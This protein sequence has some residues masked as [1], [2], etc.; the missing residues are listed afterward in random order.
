MFPHR[1]LIST[2]PKSGTHLIRKAIELIGYQHNQLEP[3]DVMGKILFSLF[4]LPRGFV[5]EPIRR[6]HLRRLW[7]KAAFWDEKIYVDVTTPIPVPLSLMNLWLRN[8]AHDGF[9]IGHVPYGDQL[10]QLLVELNYRIIVMIRDPRDVLL[11]FLHYIRRPQHM[12]YPD[13]A[14]LNTLDAMSLLIHGGETRYSRRKILPLAESF[15]LVSKWQEKPEALLL[16]FEDLVGEQGGGSAE[17]QNMV[18]FELVEFLG[19]HV[20]SMM[21]EQIRNNIYDVNARTFRKGM[22]SSWREEL[23]QEEFSLINDALADLIEI[24][25]YEL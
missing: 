10:Y 2:I 19:A 9:M 6:N 8:V 22:I 16:R 5:Y 17:R 23:S 25:G 24:M 21:I 11:S 15:R 3:A 7:S 12:L 14:D 18:L 13:F 1:V 4:N 20:D